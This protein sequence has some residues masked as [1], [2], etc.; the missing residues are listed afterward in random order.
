VTSNLKDCEIKSKYFLFSRY[1][2]DG[3]YVALYKTV[4]S[5]AELN[6]RLEDESY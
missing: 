6:W 5:V 3:T 4:M 1:K 2:R